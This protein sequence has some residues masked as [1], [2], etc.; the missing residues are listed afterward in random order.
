[1]GYQLG[2]DLQF[3]YAPGAI[4]SHPGVVGGTQQAAVEVTGSLNLVDVTF[5]Y[6]SVLFELRA[7]SV[8]ETYD[9]TN[10]AFAPSFGGGV[11]VDWM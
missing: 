3:T 9:F 5:R 1:V 2:I 6:R 10:G 4:V 7:A 8:G 11:A